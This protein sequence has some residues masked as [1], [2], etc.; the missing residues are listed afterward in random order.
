MKRR[1]LPGTN[2][3]FEE[4]AAALLRV[5]DQIRFTQNTE[6]NSLDTEGE[7]DDD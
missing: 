3:V 7:Y 6:G 1:I 4:I 2:L 5:I